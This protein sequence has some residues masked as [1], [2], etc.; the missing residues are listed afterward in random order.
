MSE[1]KKKINIGSNFSLKG[2]SGN[3]FMDVVQ[4]DDIDVETPEFYKLYQ[5]TKHQ[6]ILYFYDENPIEKAKKIYESTSELKWEDLEDNI[7]EKW[8]DISKNLLRQKI[9]MKEKKEEN[10]KE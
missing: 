5:A 8:L 1:E 9:I 3:Q 6:F 2:Y 10:K 7:K 4:L